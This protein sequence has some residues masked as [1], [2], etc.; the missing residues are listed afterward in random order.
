MIQLS[1]KNYANPSV[2]D[3]TFCIMHISMAVQ[4]TLDRPCVITR[5]PEGR[6]RKIS[7][8]YSVGIQNRSLCSRA[9]I[10]EKGSHVT[11]EHE[12]RLISSCLY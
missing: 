8:V 4:C 5:E 7:K 9:G 3:I 2:H 10:M 11:K 1:C 6:M 12:P